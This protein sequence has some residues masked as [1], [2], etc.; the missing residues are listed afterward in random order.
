MSTTTSTL[1]SSTTGRS[2]TREL[3]IAAAPERVF[4]AFTDRE[5]LKRWF[6]KDAELDLREGGVFNLTWGPGQHV[7]G[8]VVTLDPPHRFTFDWR[9][10]LG[11]TEIAVE[12]LP[13][14]DGTLLRLTHSGFGD[15]GDW[16]GYLSDIS[17]GWEAELDHLRAHLELGTPKAWD[18]PEHAS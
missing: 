10:T 6:V 16:D 4:R 3:F 15:G 14:A 12:F 18:V 1:T 11:V 2:F 9:D 13:Q 8:V 17:N 7:A 5:E